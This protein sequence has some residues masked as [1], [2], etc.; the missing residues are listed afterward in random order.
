M[1]LRKQSKYSEGDGRIGE[2]PSEPQGM[3]G[4]RPMIFAV[5]HRPHK[6]SKK[7]K[8]YACHPPKLT[9]EHLENVFATILLPNSVARQQINREGEGCISRNPGKSRH[10]PRRE[11][12]RKDGGNRISRPVP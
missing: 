7:K 9:R 2:N 11:Q 6:D 5:D 3:P 1:R 12:T 4:A 8:G 10:F